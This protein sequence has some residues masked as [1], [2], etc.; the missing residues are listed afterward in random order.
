[1]GVLKKVP[2][3][4]EQILPRRRRTTYGAKHSATFTGL[5]QDKTSLKAAGYPQGSTGYPQRSMVK[6]EIGGT[7]HNPPQYGANAKWDLDRDKELR[8]L[9]EENSRLSLEIASLR[10][11]V[12]KISAQ[13]S[14]ASRAV[15][16]A[17]YSDRTAAAEMLANINA[18][19]CELIVEIPSGRQTMDTGTHQK[20]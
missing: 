15:E 18:E 17:P 3:I 16:I 5:F 12:S 13:Q 11:V 20:Q 19:E 6:F 9:R 7:S 1:M 2:K 4:E 10:A 8:S 14:R